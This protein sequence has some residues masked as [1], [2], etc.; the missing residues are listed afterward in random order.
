MLDSLLIIEDEPLL[1]DEL[2]RRYRN[3]AWEVQLARTLAEAEAMLFEQTIE[4]LVVLS[5]V[6]LPDGNALALLEEARNRKISGEWLFLTGYGTI[7]DSVRALRLGAYDFVEKPCDLGHLDLLIVGAARSGRA[8]RRLRDETTQCHHKYTPLAFVGVSPVVTQLRKMLTQ[9]STVAYS[10]LVLT[11]ETGTGKGLTA[12]IL[13]YSSSRASGPLIELN[14]AALPREL[15]ESELFGHEAGAFTGAHKRRRGLME[16]AHKGTLFLDEVAEM[17]PELQGKLLK[18]VEE[19]RIRRVGGEKEIEIDIQIIAATNQD[20]AAA[21][22]QGQFRRDLY[23]RLSLFTLHLPPL[24]ERK[25]DLREL[26]PLFINECNARAGKKVTDVTDNVWHLLER[27]D[28]PGNVR[29]LHNVI[30]RCVLLA[31]SEQFPEQWLQLPNLT[32]TQ[33]FIPV[34]DNKIVLP[35]D[36]SLSLDDMERYIIQQVLKK[37]DHNV[38]V[39]AKMLG[40]TRETLRYRVRKYDL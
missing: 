16:Q 9:M 2:A 36:G 23:H 5:D 17:E 11:G 34:T 4:P 37:S 20:L 30:E 32:Q 28:W 15:M 38:T 6:S 22:E 14:C 21:V 7:T 39:A 25:E 40:T 27:Y 8:Q 35:L 3:Q 24:R 10:S 26:V 31:E 29:E 13:H 1:G 33:S 18:A 19:L 12:R